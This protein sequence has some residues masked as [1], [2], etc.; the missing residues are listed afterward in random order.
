[1][2]VKAK[3][4]AIDGGTTHRADYVLSQCVRIRIDELFGLCKHLGQ[5]GKTMLRGLER[6][7]GRFIFNL[8]V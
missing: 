8:G 4:S 6:V 3:G 7:G 1:V 2:A 5:A